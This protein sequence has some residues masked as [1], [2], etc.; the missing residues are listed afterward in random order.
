MKVILTNWINIL[1]VFIAVFLYAMVLNMMDTNV[2]RNLFQAIFAVLILI[3]GYGMMFWGMFIVALIVL[4]LVLLRG[5]E[6]LKMKLLIEWFIISC[7]FIY[8]TIKY[9]EWI[10]VAAIIAFLIAQLLREK[11]IS[12]VTQ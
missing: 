9:H 11:K 12:E 6:N 7:P 3:V 10:F 4:D 5:K 1:G 8:W 2:S